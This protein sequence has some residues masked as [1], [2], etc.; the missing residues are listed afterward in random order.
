[1]LQTF[2]FV[3]VVQDQNHGNR[4]LTPATF[5]KVKHLLAA[6]KETKESTYP[7]ELKEW[8]E[9]QKGL[10]TYTPPQASAV[11]FIK[12]NLKINSTELMLKLINEA[13]V[14]IGAG[15][16]FGMDGHIRIAFGQERE[17]LEEAFTRVQQTL[18]SLS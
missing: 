11:S 17:V 1:M 4:S 5:Q 7:Q 16:S 13:S 2:G 12:Y 6:C 10:F 3:P 18:E 9:S 8:M 14:F 15:D